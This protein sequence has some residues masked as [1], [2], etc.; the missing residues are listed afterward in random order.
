[1]RFES[2]VRGRRGIIA[3]I[4]LNAQS[5]VIDEHLEYDEFRR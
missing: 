2:E 1:M 4:H 5:Q 3:V